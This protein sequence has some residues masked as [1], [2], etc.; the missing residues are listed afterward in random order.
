MA[1]RPIS[2][3]ASLVRTVRNFVSASDAIDDLVFCCFSPAG[4]RFYE[5]LLAPTPH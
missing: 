4:L 2:P 1:I 3:P 5:A